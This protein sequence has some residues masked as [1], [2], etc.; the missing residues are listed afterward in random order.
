MYSILEIRFFFSDRIFG[1]DD[2]DGQNDS[3]NLSV[4]VILTCFHI[5]IKI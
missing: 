3:H 5:T 2:D 1:V 4:S